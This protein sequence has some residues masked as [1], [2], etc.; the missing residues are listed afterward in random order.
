MPSPK[1][2]NYG[3]GC[4]VWKV[5]FLAEHTPMVNHGPTMYGWLTFNKRLG[6]P[7]LRETFFFSNKMS[8]KICASCTKE[9]DFQDVA[10]AVTL[11]EWLKETNFVREFLES[12]ENHTSVQ[13]HS[14]TCLYKIHFVSRYRNRKILLWATTSP[15]TITI[16][17]A[18]SAYGDFRN[19]QVGKVNADG[20]VKVMLDMPQLYYVKERGKKKIYPRHFH[21]AFY[22]ERKKKWDGQVYTHIITPVVSR[23]FVESAIRSKTTVLLDALP[24]DVYESTKISKQTYSM[25]YTESVTK[26]KLKKA[27]SLYPKL[28]KMVDQKLLPLEEIPLLIYCKNPSCAAATTLIEK[29]L[30]LGFYNL[31]YFKKGYDGWKDKL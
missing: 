10:K 31:F 4:I 21:F 26:D 16:N 23:A 28:K 1:K 3:N 7:K 15:Q 6:L 9:D 29:L 27:L 2:L 14:K 24:H 5:K 8:Q 18:K 19:H 25:P 30:K 13:Q 12:M 22:N 11:P 20:D 17:D